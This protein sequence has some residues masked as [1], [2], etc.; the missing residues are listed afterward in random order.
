MKVG[1]VELHVNLVPR[2][3]PIMLV[4][5]GGFLLVSFAAGLGVVYAIVSVIRLAWGA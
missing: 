4:A 5:A 1:D 3:S 2:P